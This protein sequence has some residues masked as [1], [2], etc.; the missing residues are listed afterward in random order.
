MD[1]PTFAIELRKYLDQHEQDLNRS[2]NSSRSSYREIV[3]PYICC[4]TAYNSDSYVDRAYCAGMND[5]LEKPVTY[6]QIKGL[7]TKVIANKICRYWLN[8]SP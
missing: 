2:L 7:I 5:F 6:E 8:L 1:G 4:C 3:Q